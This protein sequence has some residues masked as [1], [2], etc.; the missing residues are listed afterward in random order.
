LSIFKTAKYIYALSLDETLTLLE[1]QGADLATINFIKNS[2]QSIK[3]LYVKYL[4]ENP[5]ANIYDL[6]NNVQQ[7][8]K[9]EN[10]LSEEEQAVINSLDDF[11]KTWATSRLRQIK[12]LKPG[13]ETGYRYFEDYNSA[14]ALMEI[15]NKFEEITDMVQY[16]GG[17]YSRFDLSTYNFKQ[18]VELSDEWHE[19]MVEDGAGRFYTPIL[20]NS[21]GEIVD[22]R[23]LKVFKNGWFIIDVDNENDLKVEGNKLNHCVGGY[24]KEVNSGRSKILSLR[25]QFNQPQATAEITREGIEQIKGNSNATP[26]SIAVELFS[27][28]MRENNYSWVEKDYYNK[29]KEVSW[30]RNGSDG[31]EI[32]YNIEAAFPVQG[33]P[34]FDDIFNIPYSYYEVDQ[35]YVDYRD[36]TTDIFDQYKD[37][38]AN[39]NDVA[40]E[41]ITQYYHEDHN[42]FEAYLPSEDMKNG[43]RLKKE[44]LLLY[45]LWYECNSRLE[46][47]EQV[48][49]DFKYYQEKNL[50]KEKTNEELLK[51]ITHGEDSP[52]SYGIMPYA[53]IAAVFEEL[54][55]F[56]NNTD[57]GKQY[58]ELYKK[59]TKKNFP[60]ILP[61]EKWLD[62]NYESYLQPKLIDE[63]DS[64]A[65][66]KY[67]L[68]LAEDLDKK[69]EYCQ[70]SKLENLAIKLAKYNSPS[71]KK[72]AT[73]NI[74]RILSVKIS[75]ED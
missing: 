52:V 27:D 37:S 31:D 6:Q 28:Y 49:E 22:N 54:S 20:R 32:L 65:S 7:V 51:L 43:I 35:Y 33:E 15:K 56:L 24:W 70:A 53:F 26:N 13:G 72:N 21:K 12:F 5:N 36:L 17:E 9:P 62:I 41:L 42:T 23:V 16:V 19:E 2:E 50:G 71:I 67:L 1:E 34:T 38:D 75:K 40:S 63:V 18:A 39:L 25:N 68:K 57:G 48:F 66:A 3:P 55:N 30:S 14:Q 59:T 46:D 58:K 60:T 4:K 10:S 74:K 61:P 64:T 73:S 8:K 45:D 11:I 69:G 29:P 47:F 44:N